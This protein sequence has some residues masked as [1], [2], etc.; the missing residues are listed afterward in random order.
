[1]LSVLIPVFNYDIRPLIQILH[2]Q[3]QE[4]SPNIEFWILDDASTDAV[5]QQQNA[6]IIALNAVFYQILPQNVGRARIRNLLVE[7]ANYEFLLFMDCDSMPVDDNFLKNYLA[8]C[9][10]NRLLCGGRVYQPQRPTEAN[11]YLHWHYG[12]QREAQTAAKRNLQPHFSFMTNNFVAPK[13][14]FA[15]LRFD[16]ILTGYGHEDTIFGLELAKKN[17]PIL[18]ID[19]PL[20]HIGIEKADI[21]IKK[22]EQAVKNLLVLE[23]KYGT[24]PQIR[25]LAAFYK[26]E[27]YKMVWAVRLFY[28]VFAFFIKRYLQNQQPRLFWFDVYKL[29]YL[30][31]IKSLLNTSKQN[32]N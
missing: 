3:A 20:Q 15:E 8:V 28:P 1:M 30:A 11:L 12:S 9:Q 13:A 23:K 24:L 16:E 27:K 17:I 5:L 32:G 4:L 29:L 2:R 10:P 31:R 18:H 6:E 14:I 22:T 25:L 7:K 26:L 19:N 21:F